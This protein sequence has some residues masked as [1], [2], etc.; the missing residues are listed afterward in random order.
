MYETCERCDEDVGHTGLC[1]YRCRL[2]NKAWEFISSDTP[3]ESHAV[4]CPNA[5]PNS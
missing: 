3:N 4:D 5:L 2:C 1:I